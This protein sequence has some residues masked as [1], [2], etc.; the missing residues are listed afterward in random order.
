MCSGCYYICWMVNLMKYLL[1]GKESEKRFTL[2]LSLTS[3]RSEKVIDALH[4]YYVKGYRESECLVINDL[5]RGKFNRG[6][7]I[8][9]DVAGIVEKIK[10]HDYYLG[11]EKATEEVVD[12]LSNPDIAMPQ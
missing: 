9:N 8:L 10:E 12:T 1:Q 6:S 4:D 11:R 5:A 7:K 2:I 3:V